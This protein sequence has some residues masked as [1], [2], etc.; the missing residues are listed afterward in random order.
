MH[1]LLHCSTISYINNSQFDRATDCNTVCKQLKKSLVNTPALAMP[2]FN[3]NFV[4]ETNAI[5][6][7]DGAV[8]MQYNQTDVS[9]QNTRWTVLDIF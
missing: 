5:D 4:I 2:D 8:F 1:I 3:A 6:M 9:L 7:A